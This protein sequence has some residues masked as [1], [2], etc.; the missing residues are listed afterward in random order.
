MRCEGFPFFICGRLGKL[1]KFAGGLRPGTGGT[2]GTTVGSTSTKVPIKTYI[3]G[4]GTVFRGTYSVW[5]GIVYLSR[6]IT[7]ICSFLFLKKKQCRFFSMRRSSVLFTNTRISF[8]IWALVHMNARIRSWKSMI[9]CRWENMTFGKCDVWKIC[10][11]ENMTLA[12]STSL[13]YH[14]NNTFSVSIS[15]SLSSSRS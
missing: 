5:F 8:V 11:L 14:A 4:C 1:G 9:R 12:S 7:H 13:I 15:I 6:L 3:F 2:V 10:C